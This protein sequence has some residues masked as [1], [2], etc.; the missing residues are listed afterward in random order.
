M[1]NEEAKNKQKI[2]NRIKV[3]TI[4]NY[5]LKSSSS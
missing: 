2:Y 4:K 5:Q 1:K 3:K